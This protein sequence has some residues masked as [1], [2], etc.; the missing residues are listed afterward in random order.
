V[1]ESDF[2]NLNC[3][4]LIEFYSTIAVYRRIL[5]ATNYIYYK[6]KNRSNLHWGK[7]G[8][9]LLKRN[10]ST[11]PLEVELQAY[12]GLIRSVLENCSAAWDP[13]QLY[14]QEKLESVQKRAIKL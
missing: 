6:E 5:L 12:K 7:H 9:G 14:L 13:H 3:T 1:S 10:L 2:K 11:C 4:V 8:L